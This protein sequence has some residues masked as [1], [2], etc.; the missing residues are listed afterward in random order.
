MRKKKKKS[1][2][3]PK[4][5]LGTPPTEP[6]INYARTDATNVAGVPG[7]E[8]EYE[9]PN[10]NRKE[11]WIGNALVCSI[12]APFLGTGAAAYGTR[13]LFRGLSS[14]QKG[15]SPMGKPELPGLPGLHQSN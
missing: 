7:Y 9:A 1:R 5:E 13:Q 8:G 12:F 15:T 3:I 4:Y 6:Q 11:D 14:Q 10:P 2:K